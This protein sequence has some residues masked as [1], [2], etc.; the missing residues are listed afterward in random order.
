M[1]VESKVEPTKTSVTEEAEAEDSVEVTSASGKATQLLFTEEDSVALNDLHN[2][3]TK[4]LSLLNESGS[5][6]S[7]KGLMRRLNIHQQ[8]LARA[9][10]RL[11]EMK[12]V[13]K[14]LA[15]Y[16]LAN[17]V[18][19]DARKIQRQGNGAEYV[20][21]L[22]T[23]IPI[24]V[25]PS[26][27]VRQ[28]VGKWFKSLRWLGMIEGGTGYTLQWISDDGSFQINLRLISDY[29]I[30]ETNASTDQQKVQ[31]MA[32]SYSIYQQITKVLQ[33]K[34]GTAHLLDYR[35]GPANANN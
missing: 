33:S 12:I 11:E 27:V 3:D 16:R 13:E 25:K 9:L 17:H 10:H 24:H 18:S 20:Q 32:G 31:A 23:Y 35:V 26:E 28:L 22:Q 30:I 7:F 15:G 1:Q 8:S 34:I 14:T 21:L 4:V 5:N 2:N 29:I 6:Y 19:P